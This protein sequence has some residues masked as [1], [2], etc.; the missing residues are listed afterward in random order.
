MSKVGTL[1]TQSFNPQSTA[2]L[3]DGAYATHQKT[4]ISRC[5]SVST[6]VSACTSS[7][8]SLLNGQWKVL[9]LQVDSR[10]ISKKEAI[11]ID[12]ENELSARRSLITKNI[13]FSN[14]FIR[15]FS[16]PCDLQRAGRYPKNEGG[17]TNG[18]LHLLYFSFGCQ[19]AKNE[20]NKWFGSP[21]AW[22]VIRNFLHL[23]QY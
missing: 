12:G 20:G 11:I 22:A 5:L 7:Q 17:T 18:L 16:F 15:G 21:P 6:Y 1:A 9:I 4:S 3:P 10:G 19:K 8:I 23:F 14:R 13:H 2:T